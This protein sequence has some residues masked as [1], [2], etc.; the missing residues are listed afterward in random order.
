MQKKKILIPF[1]FLIFFGSFIVTAQNINSDSERNPLVGTS[2]TWTI[3]SSNKSEFSASGVK[4]DQE[5]VDKFFYY[6]RVYV[7]VTLRDNS[8]I[9]FEGTK[10]ERREQLQSQDYWFEQEISKILLN[11][12]EKEFTFDRKLPRGFGGLITQEGFENLKN[13]SKIE[14]IELNYFGKGQ[15]L[16]NLIYAKLW[17]YLISILLFLTLIILLNTYKKRGKHVKK[18]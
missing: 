5:I 10:E 7:L 14:A 8:K 16:N 18:S 3:G 1:L 12:S 15:S 6:D 9:I 2:D 11:L 13:N 4:Y 17:I